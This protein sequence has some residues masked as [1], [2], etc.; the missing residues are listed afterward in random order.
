VPP[1]TGVNE[2]KLVLDPVERRATFEAK[3]RP[4]GQSPALTGAVARV[5]KLPL[6]PPPPPPGMGWMTTGVPL[7]G[8]AT[9]AFEQATIADETASKRAA[10][11]DFLWRMS[12][13]PR[14]N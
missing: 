7:P 13:Y 10:L 9:S 5:A 4:A 1:P 3:V 2:Q 12:E 14:V 6:E 8:D 11:S